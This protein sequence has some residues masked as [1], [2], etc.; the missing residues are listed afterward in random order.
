MNWR[1]VFAGSACPSVWSAL[2]L[3]AVLCAPVCVLGCSLSPE[4]IPAGPIALTPVI[5]R[6]PDPD[7]VEVELVA[8]EAE[9][10]YI[11]GRK[12]AVWAYRD[13]ADPSRSARVPGPLIEAKIGDLL[14]VHARNELPE[15]TTVH[16]H[17]LR[18]PAT[19]DGSTSTQSPI[20]PGASFDYTF[21]LKD[22]G[23]FWYHSHVRAD[24][25]I[26][27]GLQGAIVVRAAGEVEGQNERTLMLDDVKLRADGSLDPETTELDI[28][29]GRR[30]GV[31]LV[32][33][34]VGASI[35]AAA[36]SRER[37]RLINAANGRFFRLSL[38]H[39]AARF[40]V[41]GVDGG[42]IEEPYEE[43]ALLIAPGERYDVIAPLDGAPGETLE[44][45]T[46]PYD[47]GHG[48]LDASEELLARVQLTAIQGGA[49][50]GQEPSS[51]P[52]P[53]LERL[54]VSASTPVRPFVLE[55]DI[56]GKYG[57]L[58]FINGEFWPFNKPVPA[59]LGATEV[60]AI[61][62]KTLGAHPF[63]LHGMFFQVI[64]RDG[65]P[66]DPAGWKDTVNV[67]GGSTLRFAVRYDEPGMWMFHC[68]I[69]EHAE[70]GMMGD[71]AVM[72][73]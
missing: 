73:P 4:P 17:G 50:T 57:P 12:A 29:A 53:P 27:R 32:N 25:Q 14:V 70:R 6:D 35:V 61:D 31:L 8:S 49:A 46:L 63:H 72:D 51:P 54:L 60:W 30:G 1:R 64:E 65:A 52:P 59:T 34:R 18:L 43:A 58:F 44:L 42:L 62:N 67:P 7:V 47:A 20:L 33:G 71:L 21:R 26:E 24:D 68:Q 40:L 16:W 15:A 11:P 69:P 56:H 41:I 48:A 55:D 19:M 10:E 23:T 22:A 38:G 5:D 28:A 13:G 66:L 2:A 39:G 3:P 9:V 45:T 37:W 36:G